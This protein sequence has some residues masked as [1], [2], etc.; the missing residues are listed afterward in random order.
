[1]DKPL[2]C[3]HEVLPSLTLALL[4]HQNH[5][6]GSWNL[7]SGNNAVSFFNFCFSFLQMLFPM[8]PVLTLY[9]S[10]VPSNILLLVHSSICGSIH[11]SLHLF[12]HL[13]IHP[14]IICRVTTMCMQGI[15]SKHCFSGQ[16]RKTMK[17]CML[18]L[19]FDSSKAEPIIKNWRVL[20]VYLI[21]ES[22]KPK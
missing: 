14:S 11:P 16:P 5:S 1:M 15:F 9:F 7:A 8:A 13:I 12:L 17:G 3:A 18:Y 4:F 19:Q 6:T 20:V 21:G 2:S 22:R 10:V